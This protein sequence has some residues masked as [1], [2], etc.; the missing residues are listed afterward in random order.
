VIGGRRSRLLKFSRV[1]ICGGGSAMKRVL[2]AF[3]MAASLAL[4]GCGESGG[5]IQ[6]ATKELGVTDLKTLEY[7]GAGKWYQFGQAPNPNEPWPAYEMTSYT[8]QINFDVPAANVKMARIQIVDPKR[9]RPAPVEQ[10]PDQYVSGASAWNMAAAAAPQPAAV[11]ERTM[12]IWATPQGFLKAA[13]ANNATSKA[14]D[15]TSEVSFAI[16]KARYV[17]TINE[18]NEVSKV[19]SWIDDPVLGDMEVNFVY[20]DYKDFD[21]IKFPSKILRSQGGFPALE[22]NV[23]SVKKNPPVTITVPEAVAS[24]TPPAVNVT[25]TPLADGV[26]YLGGGSHHSVA[27]AQGDSVVV[28]EGPQ[29]EA[30]GVA[31]IAK[32]KELFPGKPIAKV[33]NSHVHFDHSGG[34]RPFVAEG[35]TVVT[36]E[37][38]KP[39]YEKAWATPRTI[40][41]DTMSASGKSATFETFGDK[42]TLAD[43]TRP[44]DIHTLQGAGHADGFVIVYLPVEKILIEVDAYTPPPAGAPLPA[45]P[46]PPAVNL[47][48]NIQ[49]LNL[50]VQQLISL[51][52]PMT[53]MSDLRTFIQ[54]PNP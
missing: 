15:K 29:N 9:A 40:A 38:N 11:A 20:T 19:T 35:A 8:A 47:Y 34:L 27:I 13:A 46:P 6:S 24:F 52:G 30:R 10:K 22:V 3:G 48:E 1:E 18:K 21:G 33:I 2:W 53:T 4:T 44:I 25:A 17:G 54:V 49:R 36:H 7:S 39:Y 26:Y 42:H 16:G 14:V 41:P 23:A 32:V 5:N 43:A 31:V 12:E 51:H 45:T 50:D 28:V 37:V